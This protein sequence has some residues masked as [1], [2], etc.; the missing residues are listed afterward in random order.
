M[1]LLRRAAAVL[2][3]NPACS[4][5]RAALGLLQQSGATFD[6]REYLQEPLSRAELEELQARLG[7]P[8]RWT[9]RGETAWVERF[10]DAEA[11]PSDVV[12]LTALA[13]APALLERP[14]FVHGAFATVGR[15]PE[16]VLALVG[17]PYCGYT[18]CGR[19]NYGY[20]CRSYSPW[21]CV[22]WQVGELPPTTA[23]APSFAVCQLD[24]HGEHE[25]SASYSIVSE[26]S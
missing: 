3:H 1:S 15:P 8:T 5:S 22:P 13:E 21:V 25:A 9:R 12:C 16:L 11:A 20:G 2:L 7:Q 10:G 4:K 23:A 6:T 18:Y 26:P 19:A 24:E 14:I 17:K